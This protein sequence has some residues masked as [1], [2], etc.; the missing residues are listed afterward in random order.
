M[1]IKSAKFL[2]HLIAVA[3]FAATIQL[4]AQHYP[5]GSEGIKAA[6]TPPPGFYVRD[7]N[8]A[9]YSD[10]IP[11]YAGQLSA[12]PFA[13]GFDIFTYVQTIRM[14]WIT[15][16]QFLGADYGM[17]IRL[18]FTYKYH[19]QK[20][21][22]ILEKIQGIPVGPAITTVNKFGLSDIQVNPLNLAWHLNQF[23]VVTG[24]SFW[25]PTGQ[26]DHKQLYFLNLGQGF[27]T[28]M[29]T[30]GVTW[31]PDADKTWAVSLLNNYEINMA[32]YSDKYVAASPPYVTTL[33]TTLGDIYTLE[34]AISKSIKKNVDLGLT[35]Y[36]QQQ[37]TDTQGPTWFGPTY[38]S[39]KIHVAGIGPEIKLA[40]EKWGLSGSL[41]YAYEF[42]ALD[43]PQGNLI[44]LTLLKSF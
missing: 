10:R 6:T 15:K 28:H 4:H 1:K 43:H 41:R 13:S 16:W 29:F 7:D 23:D 35:G 20:S 5:S 9:Y 25:V 32:Q 37:V 33:D 24:Y 38:N 42:S 27:W 40:S 30:L 22:S 31:Y 18:P 44:T 19:N 3:L 17:G 39:E 36:Y 14:E 21:P 8:S 34:W 2:R 11:G 12:N 26:Y